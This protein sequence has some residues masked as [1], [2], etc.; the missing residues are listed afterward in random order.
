[1]FGAGV[2]W[3]VAF[4]SSVD[5]SS[6]SYVMGTVASSVSASCVV[7]ARGQGMRVVEVA[8]SK[9]GEMSRSGVQVEYVAAGSVSSVLPSSGTVA[10]GTV[11]TLSGSN[12]VAGRTV[13]K[14]GSLSEVS[15]EVASSTEARC[16]APAGARGNVGGEVAT[17]WEGMSMAAAEM[18]TS[19]MTYE[20]EDSLSPRTVTP[21]QI[22][23][24]G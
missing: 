15:A 9:G 2:V 18:S 23:S 13:C 7:P 14:F 1:M 24:L 19:G 17:N 22:P 8:M 4:G 20:Y 6:W 3:L 12:F 10:G 5:G 11:V 21:S 16:V